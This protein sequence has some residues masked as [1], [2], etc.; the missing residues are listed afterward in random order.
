[1]ADYDFRSGLGFDIH[2]INRRKKKL[3]LGG[4]KISS[5]FGLEAVSDGDVVLHALSDAICG[6]ACLGDIGDYFPPGSKLSRNLDSKKILRFVLDKIKGDYQL[7][8]ADIT[9]IAD[10][11]PL[12]RHK[13]KILK[14]LSG[15][16]AGCDFNLKIKSK[17]GLCVL[18]PPESIS[19][20]AAVMAKKI[21]L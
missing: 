17:E 10:E 2:R 9:I 21:G 8:N 4:V 13:G 12:L 16:V 14:S 1:M 7:I 5:P 19:C 20:L 18:G 6:A 15:I 3:V 11:P